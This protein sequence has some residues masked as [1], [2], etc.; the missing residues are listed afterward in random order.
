MEA[1]KEGWG[2]RRTGGGELGFPVSSQR[3]GHGGPKVWPHSFLLLK[4]PA[5]LLLTN[6]GYILHLSGI[7]EGMKGK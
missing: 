5:L 6:S 4:P 7:V 2:R 3:E 1:G